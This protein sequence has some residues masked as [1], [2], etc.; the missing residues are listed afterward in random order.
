MDP[1]N[2]RSTLLKVAFGFDS[3]RVSKERRLVLAGVIFPAEAGLIGHSDADVIAHAVI[4]ALASASGLGDIGRLFPDVDPSNRDADSMLLLSKVAC[5]AAE[6]GFK[7]VNCDCVLVAERP[8]IADRT[9]EMAENLAKAMSLETGCI[10]VR[11]KTNEG[12][13]SIGRGEG[14]ASFAVMLVECNKQ[15]ESPG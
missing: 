13:D 14:M 11:G 4:D 6:L 10:S 12:M 3:H 9:A 1:M 5:M 7:V 8:K 2:S 15:D